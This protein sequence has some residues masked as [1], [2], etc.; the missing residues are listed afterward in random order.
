LSTKKGVFPFRTRRSL[1][2]PSILMRPMQAPALPLSLRNDL[3]FGYVIPT[4]RKDDLVQLSNF[5][6]PLDRVKIREKHQGR[7][8]GTFDI[9]FGGGFTRG[10]A[11]QRR[12]AAK[13]LVKAATVEFAFRP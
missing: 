10:S 4:V 13:C 3:C 7:P 8:F 6:C 1:F 12:I 5:R 11:R 9:S 2:V